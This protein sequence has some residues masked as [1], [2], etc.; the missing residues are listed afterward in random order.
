MKSLVLYRLN[1][2]DGCEKEIPSPYHFTS[3]A[4]AEAQKGQHDGISEVQ[5]VIIED[6]DRIDDAK[7]Q[8]AAFRALKR[9]SNEDRMALGLPADISEAFKQI[10]DRIAQK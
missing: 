4:T 6:G 2:W 7:P 3:L 9:L 10:Q 8:N 5:I 1:E